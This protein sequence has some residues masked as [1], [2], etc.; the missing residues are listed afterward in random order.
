M[1]Y[2]FASLTPSLATAIGSSGDRPAALAELMGIILERRRPPPDRAGGR[3]GLREWARP[4]RRTWG[5]RRS[6]STLKRPRARGGRGGAG[7]AHPG[8]R[9]G[10]RAAASSA[11]RSRRSPAPPRTVDGRQ[12]RH[13]RSTATSSTPRTARVVE[14]RVV[15]LG[16]HLRLHARQPLLR[17]TSPPTC[18]DPRPRASTSRARYPCGSPGCSCPRST[19]SPRRRR[20][21]PSPRP[22]PPSLCGR[23]SSYRRAGRRG[24]GPSRE[25][26]ESHCPSHC[27]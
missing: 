3:R 23:V 13:R 21:L 22:L 27:T 26:A 10:H 25:H 6:R 18:R 19:A 12:D 9:P 2:P 20:R 14:S 24:R 4:T 1:G 17:Y 11:R 8:R 16:G 5:A 15:S 7:Y